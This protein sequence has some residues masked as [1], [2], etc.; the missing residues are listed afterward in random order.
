MML[1]SVK[2]LVYNDVLGAVSVNSTSSPD[3]ESV[4]D[5]QCSLLAAAE[6]ARQDIEIV[7]AQLYMHASFFLE[8][9]A[10]LRKCHNCALANFARGSLGHQKVGR[11]PCRVER[12]AGEGRSS[13]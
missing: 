2:M 7:H 6:S 11:G 9:V 10:E 5:M 12:G 8:D 13:A 3:S 4:K 1:Q